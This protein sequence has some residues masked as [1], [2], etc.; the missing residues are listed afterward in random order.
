ME[1]EMEER[2]AV[3]ADAVKD[4]DIG[5]MESKYVI[6]DWPLASGRTFSR[7]EEQSA[8]KVVIIGQSLTH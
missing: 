2:A 4:V 1:A 7:R 6:R 8:G 3:G 5:E